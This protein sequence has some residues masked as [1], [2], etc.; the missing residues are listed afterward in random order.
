MLPRV[1]FLDN[2]KIAYVT[3]AKVR[4]LIVSIANAAYSEAH[5]TLKSAETRSSTDVQL[6]LIQRDS[7]ATYSF[8][9]FSHKLNFFGSTGHCARAMEGMDGSTRW[10]ARA[11]LPVRH[12]VRPPK[13]PERC[14]AAMTNI[15]SRAATNFRV[16]LKSL[17][18][19]GSLIRIPRP[20]RQQRC[21][22]ASDFHLCTP[23][24]TYRR[25]LESALKDHRALTRTGRSDHSSV[26]K[27]GWAQRTGSLGGRS[28][29]W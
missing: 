3:R 26:A 15:R 5:R 23:T 24:A 12:A 20:R 11:I 8:P 21:V 7:C 2:I 9:R 14:L 28:W 1:Q 19:S 4:Q 6:M 10:P 17:S 27:H 25:S 13:R 22:L 29:A 16:L 18:N